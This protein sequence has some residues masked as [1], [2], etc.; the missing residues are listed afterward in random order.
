MK[1]V[2]ISVALLSGC[3]WLVT[4]A[5]DSPH[6][7]C[8]SRAPAV[9]DTIQVVGGGAIAL[10]AF[11]DDEVRM[12][13]DPDFFSKL[14]LATGAVFAASAYHGFSTVSHCEARRVPEPEPLP[15]P[16]DVEQQ[17]DVTDEQ[18]D[19]HTTIRRAPPPR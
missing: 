11:T 2:A 4:R 10:G 9:Y 16:I 6:A 13:V 17:I 18:I 14:A 12:P 3:S 1:H 15:L 7:P 19:I 5:P 8:P